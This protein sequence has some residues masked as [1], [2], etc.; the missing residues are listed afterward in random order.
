MSSTDNDSQQCLSND[1]Q[2]QLDRIT[3]TVVL[4]LQKLEDL[5]SGDVLFANSS[6]ST[7]CSSKSTGGCVIKTGS[8]SAG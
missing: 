8:L 6:E 4:N 5:T 2:A 3:R 1:Q 7:T